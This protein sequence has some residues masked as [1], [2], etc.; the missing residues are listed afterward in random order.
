MSKYGLL[1][2]NVCES[3]ADYRAE[4]LLYRGF[5]IIEDVLPV[6]RL[7]ELRV[8]VDA[9]YDKQVQI[10]GED[11]I[12]TIRDGLVARNLLCH[13]DTFVEFLQLSPIV[14]VLKKVIGEKYILIAQNGIINKSKQHHYQRNWH[15]DLAYQN[16]MCSE[17]LAINVMIA[18]DDF[19][20]ESGA[21]E[22]VPF[23]HKIVKIPTDKYIEENKL[24]ACI[25]AGSAI[26][27]DSILLHKAGVN[28]SDTIL[29]RRGVN[30]IY[31]KPMM[32]Q[33]ID[34]PKAMCGKF[35]DDTHLRTVLGYEFES[36]ISDIEWRKFKYEQFKENEFKHR[37]DDK[38]LY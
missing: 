32:R 29:T 2:Q 6:D 19:T 15:R 5:T 14:E 16:Y 33:T 21:T 7:D 30:H 20:I 36:Y 23:S 10:L 18:L 17:P 35:K 24:S 13:D 8:K 25:K 22:V 34:I 1:E 31:G 4:E 11:L 26:I 9:V 12:D 37:L 3:I 38:P 28:E 27:F